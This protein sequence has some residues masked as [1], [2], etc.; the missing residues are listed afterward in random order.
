MMTLKM[1]GRSGAF[2]AIV[3]L[4]HSPVIKSVL[5]TTQ[6]VSVNCRP[7]FSHATNLALSH[8]LHY[9]ECTQR[10]EDTVGYQ[11]HKVP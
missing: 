1:T 7:A 8:S 3:L 11:L 5:L 2:W 6:L 9:D 10:A 4:L